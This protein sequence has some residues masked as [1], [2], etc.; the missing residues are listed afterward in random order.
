MSTTLVKSKTFMNLFTPA[1]LAQLVSPSLETVLSE[2]SVMFKARG[3]SLLPLWQILSLHRPEQS[4]TASLLKCTADGV[5]S[6]VCPSRVK[7]RMGCEMISTLTSSSK[8]GGGGLN[9]IP[10]SGVEESVR[11]EGLNN[12]FSS[13]TSE[14]EL[15]CIP[16]SAVE[17]RV[18]WKFI[19][20]D[21]PCSSSS[22][23]RIKIHD[24]GMRQCNNIAIMPWWISSYQGSLF[25][26]RILNRGSMTV[27]EVYKR[28]IHGLWICC[29]VCFQNSYKWL[30]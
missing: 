11:R 5:F 6:Q 28:W 3:T 26:K 16:P 21:P 7:E 14:V 22:H 24:L 15:D 8:A 18:R 20:H 29:V 13:S 25:W 30:C 12:H 17:K 10:L 23:T 27:G 19:P 2:R 9:C 1:S 4:L